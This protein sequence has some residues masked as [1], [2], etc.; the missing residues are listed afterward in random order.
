MEVENNVCVPLSFF[1]C[2]S[3][4]LSLSVYSCH[5]LFVLLYD[6]IRLCVFVGK[7]VTEVK[8]SRFFFCSFSVFFCNMRSRKFCK[9]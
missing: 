4:S 1:L 5:L 3:D 8:F 2:L 9:T 6:P 7:D